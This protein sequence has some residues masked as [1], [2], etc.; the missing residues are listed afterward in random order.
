M[1]KWLIILTMSLFALAGCAAE[2]GTMNNA[3]NTNQT[4]ENNNST[5]QTEGQIQISITANEGEE[6]VNEKEISIEEG[7]ILMDVLKNNFAVEESDGF[8]T[9]IDGVA[10][11]QEEQ[12]SWIIF[13]NGEMAPVGAEDYELSTGDE[14]TFDLQSWE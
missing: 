4:T 3:G 1:K 8:I 2:E 12:T 5:E 13:V 10:A 14:V 6:T 9:S 11:S 7:A